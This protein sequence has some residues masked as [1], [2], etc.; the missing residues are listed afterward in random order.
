MPREIVPVLPFY[1]KIQ[2]GVLPSSP[3]TMSAGSGGSPTADQGPVPITKIRA[4]K[5]PALPCPE[6]PGYGEPSHIFSPD[7]MVPWRT[8]PGHTSLYRVSA[9]YPFLPILKHD[10]IFIPAPLYQQN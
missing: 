8:R 4:Q 5:L 6:G 9:I 3:C 2:G 10:K 7:F 1:L